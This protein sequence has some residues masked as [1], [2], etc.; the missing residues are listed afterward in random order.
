[1]NTNARAIDRT[2]VGKALGRAI[3][4]LIQKEASTAA[5]SIYLHYA[6][7]QEPKRLRRMPM[8]SRRL[9]WLL[10]FVTVDFEA[11]STSSDRDQ[12][13]AVDDAQQLLRDAEGLSMNSGGRWEMP[14]DR[15]MV[16]A[17]GKAGTW[18]EQID[19]C[20]GMLRPMQQHARAAV[21][22][23]EQG[24]LWQTPRF[25][26]HVLML[27]VN[28]GAVLR[29]DP[30]FSPII[31]MHVGDPIDLFAVAVAEAIAGAWQFTLRCERAKCWRR[32]MPS[33]GHQKRC[34]PQC[35]SADGSARARANG[36]DHKREY[37]KNGP[38]L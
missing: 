34:S 18:Q 14:R 31:T 37:R 9:G 1:M 20:L 38:A 17:L 25:A 23:A 3:A 22:A 12:R 15:A 21:A 11:W 30:D 27:T 6:S 10:D 26:S 7:T 19:L 5:K 4:A 33:H 32:F 2:A 36:R 35:T 8:S 13:A 28:N 29:N 24:Q 16:L